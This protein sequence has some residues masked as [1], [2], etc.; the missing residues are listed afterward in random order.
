[1]TQHLAALYFSSP[2]LCLHAGCFALGAS[3]TWR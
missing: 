2:F 3:F 1:V